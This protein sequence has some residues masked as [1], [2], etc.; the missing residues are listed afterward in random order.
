MVNP[1]GAEPLLSQFESAAFRTQQIFGR[2][3]AVFVAD[4]GVAVVAFPRFSHDRD[5]ADQPETWC[6]SRYDQ[7]TGPGIGVGMFGIGN[8]ITTANAAPSAAVVNHLCPLIT[9]W[10]PSY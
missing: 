6:L 1:P 7:H 3:P 8:A 9:Y 2:H 10:F 5:V 4:F